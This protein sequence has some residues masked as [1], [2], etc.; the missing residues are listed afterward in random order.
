MNVEARVDRLRKLTKSI[1]DPSTSKER[2]DL[3][4]GLEPTELSVEVVRLLFRS[5]STS[6]ENAQWLTD[7]TTINAIEEA[8]L[9]IWLTAFFEELGYLIRNRVPRMSYVF[10][11]FQR[12][13]ERNSAFVESTFFALDSH[14]RADILSLI[15]QTFIDDFVVSGGSRECLA[16]L[17]MD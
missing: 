7:E 1:D 3:I 9:E 5:L 15:D 8:P 17:F 12:A 14:V 13:C 16:F 6:I 2:H 11:F 4:L 10:Y